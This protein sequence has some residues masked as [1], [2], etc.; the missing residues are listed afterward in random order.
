M[1]WDSLEAQSYT[2]GEGVGN[3]KYHKRTKD[4]GWRNARAVERR[5]WADWESVKKWAD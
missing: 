1:T 4:I 5:A 3:P 2:G